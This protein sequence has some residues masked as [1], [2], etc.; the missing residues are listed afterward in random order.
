[1]E[2]NTLFRWKKNTLGRNIIKKM[3]KTY[4]KK[5]FLKLLETIIDFNI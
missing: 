3:C 2:E 4:R 1:M 5:T